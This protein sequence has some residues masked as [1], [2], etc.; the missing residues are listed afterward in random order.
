MGKFYESDDFF[1]LLTIILFLVINFEPKVSYVYL[2]M[3]LI[4]W[5]MYSN[6]VSRKI[7]SIPPLKKPST[8]WSSG[9]LYGLVGFVVFIFITPVVLGF[10]GQAG[11]TPNSVLELMSSGFSTQPVL[12]QS[13]Y[14]SF[15]V[16]GVLI[17]YIQTLFFPVI[18][19]LTLANKYH[20]SLTSLKGQLTL[21]TLIGIIAVFF[22]L[23]AKGI[24]NNAALIT[25]FIFFF[26]NTYLVIKFREKIQAAVM[27]IVG[28]SIAINHLLGIFTGIKVLG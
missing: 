5:M 2:G 12:E 24:T 4:A 27:H 13:K 16:W 17:P 8:T 11:Y 21:M 1:F 28:N 20:Y 25:T 3:A 19:M 6:V 26:I 15:A 9:I 14:T 10:A 7:F 23:T 18:L 22:H